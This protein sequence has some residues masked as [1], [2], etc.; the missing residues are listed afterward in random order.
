M[1]LTPTAEQQARGYVASNVLS[2][3]Q[4]YAER[5]WTPLAIYA[6]ETMVGVVLHGRWP[7]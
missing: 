2:L 5:W 3:A 7:E 4:A 1:E 6:G